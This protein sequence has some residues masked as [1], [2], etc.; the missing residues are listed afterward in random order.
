[1][2]LPLPAGEGW[3][4]GVPIAQRVRRKMEE[5]LSVAVVVAGLWLGFHGAVISAE[6]H[7]VKGARWLQLPVPPQ[8]KTG[9][10]LIGPER[11]GIFFTNVLD[12]LSSAANRVLENGS[13]VA[14]GDFDRDG[15]PDI[16]LC[17]LRG[18]NALYRNLGGWRFEEVSLQAGINAT[19]YVCRGAVFADVNGDGWLDLLISTLRHGVLC[20]VN[21]GT[22]KFRD[23]TPLAATATQFGSTTLALA[24]VDGNGTL[25]LYVTN[26]RAEDIRDRSRVEVQWINGRMVL[27][28]MYRDRLILTPGGLLEFGEPDVLYLNDGKGR[29]T[30]VSWTGG[31]FLDE[32]GQALARPP[33]DWGLTATFRDL[34]GDGLPDLYVCNDYWTPDRIWINDGQGH[35][36]AMA[37]LA[38]RHTSENSMGVDFADIDRDGHLDFLVLDMVSRDPAMRRRQALAQTKM[39]VNV[40]EIANRPQ[41]MRNTLFHNRGDGTFEEIADFCG[42]PASDWSWQPV[43]IDVDLDGFDDLIIPA[44]HRRDVQDMD[45]TMRIKALQHPWPKDMEPKARQEAFT[46]EMA[47]TTRLYPELQMPIVAFR[48][49]GHLKFEEVTRLWGTDTMGVHQGIALADFDGDGGLDLVVNNLN[50]VC[51][52][53]RNDGIAPRVAVRLKGQPPNTQGIGASVQLLGGAVPRQSQEVVCGGRY[54]SG[55]DPELVFAAGSLT[56]VMQLEIV[57]RNGKHTQIANVQPNRLYEIEEPLDKT[58]NSKLQTPTALTEQINSASRPTNYELRITNN[59]IQF[60]NTQTPAH[61]PSPIFQDVSDRLNHLHVENTFDD[62]ARQPLLPKR[63]SQLGPGVSWYDLNGDGHE[64]LIIGSGAGGQMAVYCNDGRGGFIKTNDVLAAGPETRDLTTVLAMRNSQGDTVVLA[65]SAN[66]EDGLTNGPA[67][68]QFNLSRHRLE[69]TQASLVSSCGPLALADMDGD[70]VLELFVGGRVVPGRY[71]EPASSRIYRQ[72]DGTWRQDAVNCAL[73]EKVGLVSGAVWS[74]LD[75]DGLPELIL[76]C[77]WGPIRIFHHAAGRLREVT[78]EWGM[79]KYIGWWS[80]VTTGD[81]DGDGKLDIVAG[82]WG[83]NSPYQAAPDQPIR[84]YYGDFNGQGTVDLFESEYHAGRRAYVPRHRLDYMA[85]GLPFLL[86]KSA[87]FKS[88]S[89]MTIDQA[90]EGRLNRAS[91]LEARTLASMIFLNRGHRFEAVELPPQAQFAPVFSVNVGDFDGDGQED[92]FLSQNFF[93]LPWEMH[94][95]DAGRGLWLKGDGTGKFNAVPGQESGVLVYGEQRGAA[96]GDFNNDGRIDLAVTQNGAAT[97]LY[98]NTGAKPGL[99]VRLAGPSANPTGV[100]AVI[101]LKFGDRFGPAREIHAGSGHWSQDSAVQVMGMPSAPSQAQVRWPGGRTVISALPPNAR[102][103]RIDM[104]GY[105]QSF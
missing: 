12:D 77:E 66:Y 54:L 83:F 72:Q 57:W 15:R 19:N 71:P 89:E 104:E 94:R 69:D 91:I 75:S 61:H 34:N 58:P 29:F 56:N 44:G 40:G 48:N 99:R 5:S 6:W 46:R 98:L 102:D 86:D 101:R 80:G 47:Q 20:Y 96:L 62:F 97:K 32:A 64:D 41:I 3:G 21:D 85:A 24:D 55:F 78:A 50:G 45:A 33:L 30:P 39:S 27:P 63:L 93:A 76:A 9:F 53:Y 42:L 92:V 10:T 81:L 14:V 36:R 60:K 31:A 4:E 103:I 49:L 105:I 52:I 28:P 18:A 65:G 1:M 90:L 22:G 43:F 26:Y 25:D 79:D 8:G 17:S 87:S 95:Q 2:R 37:Q 70:G 100:G 88:F 23:A 67:F 74:D 51:G 73:L 82:N 13:G 11:T 7:E 35:F 68:W 16:F 38:I 84:L 59:A